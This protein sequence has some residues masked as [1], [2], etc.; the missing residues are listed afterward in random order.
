[1]VAGT[2]GQLS[3]HSAAQGVGK[4]SGW[5]FPVLHGAGRT[6]KAFAH[7]A[8]LDVGKGPEYPLLCVDSQ[9]KTRVLFGE[10]KKVGGVAGGG[11]RGG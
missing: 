3:V 6:D 9:I 7:G 4:L 8:A 10:E 2:N 1:M 5:S 11:R